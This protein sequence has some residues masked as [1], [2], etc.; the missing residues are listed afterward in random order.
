MLRVTLKA[1]KGDVTPYLLLE[2]HVA[3]TGID[4]RGEATNTALYAHEGDT[5]LILRPS[6][7]FEVASAGF[8][9]TSDALADLADGDERGDAAVSLGGLGGD[10]GSGGGGHGGGPFY[11]GAGIRRSPATCVSL[12]VTG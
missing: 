6:A 1:L 9:G 12:H 5:H 8:V 10:L 7:P 3:N 4:D 11:R 2:P